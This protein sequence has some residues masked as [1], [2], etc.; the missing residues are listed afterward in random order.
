MRHQIGADSRNRSQPQR[1]RKRLPGRTRQATDLLCFLENN[2]SLFDNGF[3]L[4]RDRNTSIRPLEHSYSKH[5][6]DFSYLC[7]ERGLSDMTRVR[8]PAE[9]LMVG[10]RNQIFEIAK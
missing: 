9:M 10:D 2:T 4:S 5:V 3:A 1:T 7:A 8:G 6:L